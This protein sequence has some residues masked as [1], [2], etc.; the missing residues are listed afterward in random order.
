MWLNE[1]SC[2]TWMCCWLQE[3]SLPGKESPNTAPG[4]TLRAGS[5]SSGVS[6]S[7]LSLNTTQQHQK[8]A[9]ANSYLSPPVICV[10]SCCIKTPKLY[11]QSHNISNFNTHWAVWLLWGSL[12]DSQFII[13]IF[14]TALKGSIIT[15][16]G[17]LL[18]ANWLAVVPNG[19]L[20]RV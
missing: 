19:Y 2:L 7:P 9:G 16:Y 8:L 20:L 4:F 3:L 12:V 15:A 18:A 10:W 14:A 1:S 5:S 11:Q 13:T 17:R 6:M